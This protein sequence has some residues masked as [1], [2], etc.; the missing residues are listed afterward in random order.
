VY[1][2][3]T[4]LGRRGEAMVRRVYEHLGQVRH[5]AGVVEYRVE[6]HAAKL[7]ERLDRVWSLSANKLANKATGQDR[8]SLRA[9]AQVVRA[10]ACGTRTLQSEIVSH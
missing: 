8:R 5:R 10:R 1:A 3:A 2:V 7:G 4:E 6:Q 9:L